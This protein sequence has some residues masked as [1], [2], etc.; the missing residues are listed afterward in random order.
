VSEEYAGNAAFGLLAR[1]RRTFA[2]HW[3][4]RH[5]QRGLLL[6]ADE[7]E[8]SPPALALEERPVSPTLRL[9]AAVLIAFVS[10]ALAW[11]I[12]ARVDIAVSATGKVIPNGWT[13]TIASVD[14]ASVRAVYVTD[15][16]VVKKG[17][18]L[19]ELDAREHE[20]ERDKATGDELA[21][22]LQMARSRALIASVD[23][24]RPPRLAPMP[25]VSP[26][27]LGDAQQHLTG[28]YLDYSAK[29]AQ[30]DA[31]IE[32]YESSLPLALERERIY[33]SLLQNRDVSTDA[34]LAK[35][36]DRLDLEGRLADARTARLVLIAQTRKEAYDALTEAGKSAASSEQDAVKAGSHARWL[37]LRAPVDGTVQQVAVHTVGG[38]VQAAQP[39]LLIVP[40]EKRIEVEAFLENK[41]IGFVREGQ[42][43]EVKVTA[44]DYTRFG[45]LSGSVT[46]VSHDAIEQDDKD[47][48]RTLV[49]SVKVLLNQPA[50]RVQGRPIPLTP[51]MSVDVDIKTGTRRVIEYVLSPLLRRQHESLRER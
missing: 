43:A 12:L 30:L 3:R 50:I 47:K 28:Q 8:F 23:E 16:Q 33:A 34:W 11:A 1:H 7:A 32:R 21:A 37:T 36:Q 35:K 5:L 9:T 46:T 25:G 44:F 39:L 17:D 2:Y 19:V 29:L 14:T 15:G 26:Q 13:K 40:S 27:A 45:T 24:H 48:G 51:G 42:R 31:D 6:T 38:V 20:A 41:D 18:V 49:Y 10:V 22:R 4:H